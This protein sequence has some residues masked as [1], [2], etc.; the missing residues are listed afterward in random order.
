MPDEDYTADVL[1]QY[2]GLVLAADGQA[3]SDW[4]YARSV[5]EVTQRVLERRYFYHRAL[6]PQEEMEIMAA[7]E[8]L[9]ACPIKQVG[10]PGTWGQV[11]EQLRRAVPLAVC[12]LRKGAGFSG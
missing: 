9:A 7:L 3:L 8:A 2:F 1:H 6:S 5:Y 4:G 11:Q 12:L 10:V